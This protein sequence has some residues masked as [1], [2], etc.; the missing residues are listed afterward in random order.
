[1]PFANGYTYQRSVTVDNTKV[2]G[3]GD[4]TDFP[5]LISGT[6]SYLATTGNGGKV[7]NA[8]GYDIIFTSDSAGNILLDHEIELYTATTGEIAFWVRIPTLDGD[9]DTTFYMFYG[10]SSISTSQEDKEGVWRSEFKMVQHMNQSSDSTPG[11][12]VDSTSNNNDGEGGDMTGVNPPTRVAGKIGYGQQ[13][14]VSGA[15]GIGVP[16]SATL[17]QTGDITLSMWVKES[18]SGSSTWE[19]LVSKRVAGSQCNYQL[20]LWESSQ[21]ISYQND[22]SA[23]RGNQAVTTTY[24]KLTAVVDAAANNVVIYINGASA[25]TMSGRDIGST[26]NADFTIGYWSDG[27]AKEFLSA[28][29]DEVRLYQGKQSDDWIATEYNSENDPSTFYALGNENTSEAVNH[30]LASQGAGT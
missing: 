22:G 6:Y 26:N 24:K 2:S 29:L 27:T 30:F 3:A 15:S 25:Q 14:S 10:N 16:D 19:V 11:E 23:T 1:M 20:F 5:V 7:E 28:D 8:N 21:D 4:L 13:F 18:G 17:D 12:F 9:A